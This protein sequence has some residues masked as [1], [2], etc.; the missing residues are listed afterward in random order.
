ME[1]SV[2]SAD[3]T[4]LIGM[5]FQAAI[6]ANAKARQHLAEGNIAA[7]S[8]QIDRTC[9]IIAELAASLDLNAGGELSATLLHLYAYME[10]RLEEADYAGADRALAEVSDLLS[11]LAEGWHS[12]RPAVH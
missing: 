3:P 1:S 10:R 8:R 4:E 7:R 6:E 2:L 11:A 5:L 9:A 12:C